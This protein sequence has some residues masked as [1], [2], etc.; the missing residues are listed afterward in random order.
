MKTSFV[1]VSEKRRP[2]DLFVIAQFEKESLHREAA[3]LEPEFAKAAEAASK[4]GRFEAKYAQSVS[5]YHPAYHEAREILLIG[6]GQKKNYRLA[7]FRKAI[8]SITKAASARKAAHVR[9]LLDSFL[10]GEVKFPEA[11]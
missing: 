6:L 5:F 7:C 11:A 8:A 4:S 3:S 2:A 10:A 9:I 1:S